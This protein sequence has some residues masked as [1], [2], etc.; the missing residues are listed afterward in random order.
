[1]FLGE[2]GD[3]TAQVHRGA[4]HVGHALLLKLEIPRL[5]PFLQFFEVT[6]FV[7]VGLDGFPE[8]GNGLAVVSP[9]VMLIAG[10]EFFLGRSTVT[11]LSSIAYSLLKDSPWPGSQPEFATIPDGGNRPS[12]RGME[13]F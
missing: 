1:L 7:R 8:C 4:T 6:F 13:A 2:F 10:L 5:Q 11:A 3:H 9:L 12:V